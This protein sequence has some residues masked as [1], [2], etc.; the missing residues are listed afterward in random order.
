[1]PGA[2]H[3]AGPTASGKSAVALLVAERVGG[4]IISVD[5]MQVYRGLNIGTAKPSAQERA[6]IPHHLVDVAEIHETFDTARFL[7]LARM[8][9]SGIRSR[10]RTPVFCGGTG[11]YFNAL[12]S[13]IGAAPAPNPVMRAELEALPLPALL[14]ELAKRDPEVFAQIDRANPRRVVRAVEIVRMTGRPVSEQRAEWKEGAAAGHWFGLVRDRT[15]LNARIHE[16]VDEMFADGLVDET[17]TLLGNGL[18]NNRTATQAIGYRQ[19]VEY[20][21]GARDLRSTIE[22]VQQ[23]TR[24]YAKRQMTWFRR[25]LKI[26]WIEVS[27]QT[28]SEQVAEE[29]FRRFERGERCDTPV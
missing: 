10:G 1:M 14:D 15:D 11:L 22:L 9:E 3:I 13:G 7:A 20:L 8:A 24:Q 6:R 26:E 17:R 28:Q 18:E 12:V 5:S 29:I 27:A 21:R 25:Q 4:E 19:V 23:K 16:R 2:I